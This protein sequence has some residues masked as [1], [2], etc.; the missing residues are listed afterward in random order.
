MR[1]ETKNEIVITVIVAL[2]I[3]VAAL[4]GFNSPNNSNYTGPTL[5]NYN[6]NTSTVYSM[7]TTLSTVTNNGVSTLDILNST[8]LNN[9]FSSTSNGFPGTLSTN[10]NPRVNSSIVNPT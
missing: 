3:V 7:N 9:R 6:Y 2:L 8:N 5:L 10:I 4:Y 1:R